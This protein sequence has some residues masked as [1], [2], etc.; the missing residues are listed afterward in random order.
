MIVNTDTLA[1]LFTTFQALWADQFLAA[2]N[3][4]KMRDL[5]AMVVDSTTDTESYN[6]L[7]TVPKMRE[8]ISERQLS[9][10]SS[11]NYSIQNKNYEAS[12]EVDRN[13]IEDDKY[14]LIRPRIN[15]LAN[16]AVRYQEELAI[17]QLINGLTLLCY[18]GQFFFDTDHVDPGA[19]YQTN[20]SN[21][22]TGSG[23]TIAAFRTDY[24]VARAAMMNFKDGQGRPMKITPTHVMVPPA[25]EGVARQIL[26]SEFYNA[27]SVAASV[28]NVWK[29]TAE[30]VV[31]PLLSDAN[32]WYLLALDQPVK[33]LIFQNRRQPEFIP[34]D[35]PDGE[36]AFMRR[37]FMYGIDGRF[38][39]G[40]GLW[41]MAAITT[42]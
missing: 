14:Q 34:M 12:L 17:N 39:V 36:V 32:D 21:K 38:G 28:S 35:K 6:W 25:L 20:Q 41:Q 5:L 4:A 31:E 11:H 2:Q 7:G 8:W 29:G 37:R 23:V 22:L 27:G 15:Q 3:Q 42:N 1:A 26:N 30:L 10:L 19:T 9:G 18:D 24:E 16:E 13:T 40:Y 33:P